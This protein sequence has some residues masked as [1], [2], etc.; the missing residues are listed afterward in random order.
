MT[1]RTQVTGMVINALRCFYQNSRESYSTVGAKLYQIYPAKKL[2]FEKNQGINTTRGSLVRKK[3]FLI[4]SS[5][6]LYSENLRRNPVL[7]QNLDS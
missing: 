6:Y 5:I 3:V 7:S 2:F 4:E 1:P